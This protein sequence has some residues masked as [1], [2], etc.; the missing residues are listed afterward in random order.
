MQN[1]LKLAKMNLVSNSYDSL[2]RIL[3]E[4]K[5]TCKTASGSYDMSKAKDLLDAFSIE[6]KM[7]Q[8]LKDNSRMKSLYS[9]T[10]KLSSVI[11]DPKV[12]AV[13]K[14]TG[15][16][17]YMNEKKWELAL[18][19][20]FESY[21]NYL[22]IGDFRAKPIFKYVI[23]ASIMANSKIN[24][25]TLREGAIYQ[26]D[27]EIVAIT[28]LRTAYENN[29]INQIQSIL[30][31][32]DSHILDDPIISMYLN[33]LLRSIRL[34]VVIARIKPYKAVS[35]SYLEN[36]LGV[37]RDVICSLLEELI[38]EERIRGQIDQLNGFLELQ[39][40]S[41][42]AVSRH[43]ELSKWAK[44]LS[45]VHSQLMSQLMINT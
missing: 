22:E 29:D 4:V 35:L 39:G 18:E 17:I 40:D 14:E 11:N 6:I 9:E 27:T 5:D 10:Q 34:N 26:H 19:E 30:K 13:I 33:D 24:Y 45:R 28:N 15:G 31:N 2:D 20:L 32:K 23:L 1:C 25:A 38:L 3:Q 41:T 42:Q 7:C 44:S 43:A 37:T 8:Q 21:K 36:Q 12:V 16:I